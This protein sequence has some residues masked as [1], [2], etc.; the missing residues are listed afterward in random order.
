MSRT[1]QATLNELTITGKEYVFINPKTRK[2][3]TH[4]KRSFK[5][6]KERADLWPDFHF[7]NLRDTWASQLALAGAHP[8]MIQRVGGWKT[9]K[10]VMKYINLA[11]DEMLRAGGI[12]EDRLA[13]G[14]HCTAH[15]N[16]KEVR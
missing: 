6:A 1:L 16:I 5:S 8:K 10:Q 4:V 9:I 14:A 12:I 13:G 3:Y 7:R 2:P 11:D 15:R